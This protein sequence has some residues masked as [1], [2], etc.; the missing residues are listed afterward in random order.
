MPFRI[1]FFMACLKWKASLKILFWQNFNVSVN[2]LCDFYVWFSVFVLNTFGSSLFPKIHFIVLR[3]TKQIVLPDGPQELCL[4]KKCSLCMF[5]LTYNYFPKVGE[6][7]FRGLCDFCALTAELICA[8]Y[9]FFLTVN[10]TWGGD[11]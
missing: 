7:Y 2:L 11:L 1:I 10:T 9:K 3:N 8:M 6:K 4:S 5:K